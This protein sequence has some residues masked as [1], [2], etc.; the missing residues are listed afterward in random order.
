M[1]K[2]KGKCQKCGKTQLLARKNGDKCISCH[3]DEH[4]PRRNKKSMH[5][6]ASP[7]GIST[8]K[9]ERGQWILTKTRT[10]RGLFT[11]SEN[12]ALIRRCL[13]VHNVS[14]TNR[15]VKAKIDIPK[16]TVWHTE[17][18]YIGVHEYVKNFSPSIWSVMADTS[19]LL[20]NAV[21]KLIPGEIKETDCI[22]VMPYHEPPKQTTPEILFVINRKS[23]GKAN[24]RMQSVGLCSEGLPQV[25]IKT[26]QLIKAG[27]ELF[28]DYGAT[29][30]TMEKAP[31][32][33]CIKGASGQQ[34][35]VT[36]VTKKRLRT[37][38]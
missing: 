3:N 4:Y 16:G 37:E 15:T 26:M 7:R 8:K 35:Q 13:Q 19:K 31:R 12:A 10:E 25:R 1:P 21:E 14:V 6:C 18:V 32:L 20:K 27:A 23:H 33:H 38:E 28:A 24:V 29:K 5:P 17:N 34:A 22:W 11:E 9:M 2:S 30:H 36:H